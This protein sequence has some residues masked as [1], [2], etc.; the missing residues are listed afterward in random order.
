[1]QACDTPT[2]G[3][4]TTAPT[5]ASTIPDSRVDE[6][7]G[8]VRKN[9]LPDLQVAFFPNQRWMVSS[10]ASQAEAARVGLEKTQEAAPEVNSKLVAELVEKGYQPNSKLPATHE[11]SN[12]A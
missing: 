11:C 2:S 12:Q 5:T 4:A 7:E 9:L 1:M 8:S 3:G 10:S 6:A